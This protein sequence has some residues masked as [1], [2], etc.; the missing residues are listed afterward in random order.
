MRSPVFHLPAYVAAARFV[1]GRRVLV[2]RP[3]SLDG[4]RH[5]L[6]A[7][8]A[9]VLVIGSGLTSEP[10]ISVRDAE[11]GLPLRD[12]SVD[13]VLAIESF[14]GLSPRLRRE[15]LT[16]ADRVLRHPGLFG[17]WI[18]QPGVE[19]FGTTLDG[20]TGVDFWTLEDELAGLF[21]HVYLLAQMPWQ[22]FSLAA[23]LDDDDPAAAREPGLRLDEQLLREPPR[24]SHYLG[25]ASRVPLPATLASECTL[26]PIPDGPWRDEVVSA[27]EVEELG[28]EIER[29]REELSVRAAKSA[30]AARRAQELEQQLDLLRGSRVSETEEELE[31][32]REDLERQEHQFDAL[33]ARE[34]EAREQAERLRSELEDLRRE[35]EERA[36]QE[37]TITRVEPGSLGDEGD[38]PE[39]GAEVPPARGTPDPELEAERDVL[40]AERDDLLARVE[41]METWREETEHAHAEARAKLEESESDARRRADELEDARRAEEAALEAAKRRIAELVDR[42][43]SQETDLSILTRATQDQQDAIARLT[44]DVD[45]KRAALEEQRVEHR[46][47]LQR[48]TALD[49]ER[50]ELRRQV[51]VLM[52][53]REGSRQLA[54]RVE[55]EL[56]IAKRKLSEQES[57][58][59]ERIEEASRMSGAAEAM[60][61]RLVE[62][63]HML[64]ETR[65]KAEKLSAQAEQGRLFADVALDRDRLR[66]ELGQRRQQ[67]Q[68]LEERLWESR[69]DLQR[70]KIEN[71]R[72]AGE[73]ER[74]RE[75]ADRSRAV[76]RERSSEIEHLGGAMRELEVE[77]AE[78]TAN[79]NAREAQI[80][81]LQQELRELTSESE[82]LAALRERLEKRGEQVASLSSQL[83]QARLQEKQAADLARRR[84]QEL[85]QAGETLSKVRKA[86]DDQARHAAGLQAELDV[87]ALENED[88]RASLSDTQKRVRDLEKQLST[89]DQVKQGLQGKLEEAAAD[90][91]SLRTQLR[92]RERELDELGSAQESSALELF[93]LRRELEGSEPEP[94]S[95][96]SLSL[97][98]DPD[99]PDEARSEVTRLQRELD[100]LRASRL[101]DQE[102][103]EGLEKSRG[104]GFDRLRRSQLEAHVRLREQ[105]YMLSRLDAA[106]QRI[107]EMTDATDRNAARFQASLAQLE[108]H[109]EKVDELMDELE[110]TRNLLA[111]EQARALEQERLLASERAK[112]ARAGLGVTGLPPSP[113]EETD[114]VFA[115]LAGG[116]KLLDLDS[117]ARGGRGNSPT[118]PRRRDR[119]ASGGA[120]SGPG[121][122]HD[123]AQFDDDD[124]ALDALEGGEGEGAT[125][126]RSTTPSKSASVEAI[127]AAVPRAVEDKGSGRLGSWRRRH[128]EPRAT[129]VRMVVEAVD[130]DDEW[131]E[132]EGDKSGP[133]SEAGESG[134]GPGKDPLANLP[135]PP[136]ID[137]LLDG[138][139]DEP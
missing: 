15:L 133:T 64:A 88:F 23:V 58:L 31:R 34:R 102:R 57:E 97:G 80:A 69:D 37:S 100:E 84:E 60:R 2:Y 136:S 27:Q 91:R 114:D 1:V 51:E 101:A 94:S 131:P 138:L 71:V 63:D 20:A 82:D 135:D 95:E 122:R 105:E 74:L 8:A 108:K 59:A 99:W 6:E 98:G 35:L 128:S 50:E 44:H 107:W 83:E 110:V 7:G 93:R 56:E 113:G 129:K 42:L 115:D 130:E 132:E 116:G 13:V 29:L 43:K 53:E 79:L 73:L 10:G 109:K 126:A 123:L 55:A 33:R 28:D 77:R 75:Q 12:Q 48:V 22:G 104:T 21:G 90:Q 32:L 30:A 52:A 70:E 46:A 125:S 137:E 112:L 61:E 39:A 45:D 25:L 38:G 3:V 111:T 96:G 72:L 121:M 139:D 11:R 78:L 19:A 17:C 41:Q 16:E 62:Q 92:S 120:V 36:E 67:I 24:A 68:K 85:N 118:V 103:W 87:R 26:V 65:S 5:L 134:P 81:D 66:E 18:E 76:E 119:A 9:E 54:A 49:S 86:L 106:E 117:A 47:L 40:A 89:L 127:D 14:G 4:A 124:D